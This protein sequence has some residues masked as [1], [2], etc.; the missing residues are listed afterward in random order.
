MITEEEYRTVTNCSGWFNMHHFTFDEVQNF[1]A[2]LG[3][4]I[5][6]VEGRATID[7][8][9]DCNNGPRMSVEGFVKKIVALKS[10]DVLPT[11]FDTEEFY[12]LTLDNVFNREVK[13][14]LLN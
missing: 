12:A 2:R 4:E 14:K 9:Q 11:R 5:K 1:L 6:V 8:G 10:T 3:Y 13:S 7:V